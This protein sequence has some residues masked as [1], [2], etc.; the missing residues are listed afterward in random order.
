[1]LLISSNTPLL[2]EQHFLVLS[3]RSK[4]NTHDWTTANISDG[5]I[6]YEKLD[7]N[8]KFRI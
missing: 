7:T 6:L 4:I 5:I 2:I 1:M 3:N 8:A